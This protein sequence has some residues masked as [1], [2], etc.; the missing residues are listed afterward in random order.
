MNDRPGWELIME[1]R[2]SQRRPTRS[3]YPLGRIIRFAVILLLCWEA[4]ARALDLTLTLSSNPNPSLVGQP[5]SLF[6]GLDV[7][8]D[9]TSVEFREGAQLLGT[10][11]VVF[12]A[13]PRPC[14]PAAARLTISNLPVGSHSIAAV[15]TGG[16]GYNPATSN[17]ISQV[18]IGS[19][20]VLPVA[21]LAVFALL[22]SV[23]GVLAL[24]W[25]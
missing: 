3:T 12:Q 5:V 9:G 14:P 11:P 7:F 6:V 24:L 16:G 21:G 23:V 18:L 17:T 19:I 4:S 20:P 22:L 10:S 1:L 13:C 25:R 8:V 2:R 15:F